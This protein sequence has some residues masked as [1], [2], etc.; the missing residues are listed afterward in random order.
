MS[1]LAALVAVVCTGL[2]DR[3]QAQTCVANI[4]HTTGTWVTLPYPM[5]INPI[6]VTLMRTGHVLVVA[7]SENSAHNYSSTAQSFRNAVWDPAGTTLSSVSVQNVDYDVFCSGVGVLP[8]GR[9]LIVGGTSGY[10]FTGDNRAAFFDPATGDFY[11]APAMADGRWYATTT[12]LGDGRLMALLRL[13]PDHQ[14]RQQERGDLRPGQPRAGVGPR[15]LGRRVPAIRSLCIRGWRS[16]RPARCSTRARSSGSRA[17]TPGCSIRWRR[18]GR[19][20]RRRLVNRNYG[21]SVM[22]PLLPPSYVPKVMNFGGGDSPPNNTTEIINLSQASPTYTAGPN[23]SAARI[24]MNAVLLPD[25]TVLALG[26]SAVNEVPDAPG[27]NA[28]LYLGAAIV[29]TPVNSFVPAG[30]GSFSRLYHSSA[31]LLPDAR[32]AVVGSNPGSR[33]DYEPAIEIYTPAYLYDLNDQLI[34][35][36]RPSIGGVVPTSGVLGY[37]QSFTVNYSTVSAI[38]AAVLVRPGSST[39]AVDM[40][41]RLI[42]LCSPTSTACAGPA[43]TLTLVTPP[44][45]NVAPPGYYMLFLLDSAGVPSVARFVQLTATPGTPPVGTIST[46]ASDVTIPAGGSVSFSTATSAAKYGWVF[47]GGS[48]ATSTAQNPGPVT[49]QKP[50]H[51]RGVADGGGRH[52]Q[53]GSEPADAH[54]PGDPGDGG[55]F[56]R[57]DPAGARGPAGPVRHGW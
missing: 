19:S 3:A 9:P 4:P 55:L 17:P 6:S 27:K 42:V 56:D 49:F 20:R 21:S 35:A 5:P 26:G 37:A 34:T 40:E 39:H 38:S 2:V 33:G 29:D 13:Q 30:T 15:G 28:D 11:Q 22:L 31:L 8:D 1:I 24:E 50:G 51:V 18:R 44:N 10:S 14:H 32:V 36:A 57:R 52:R 46:P 43:G 16:C 53:H 48:P 47:P 54:H 25:G 23:M 7:G 45:G 12:A 41:Q